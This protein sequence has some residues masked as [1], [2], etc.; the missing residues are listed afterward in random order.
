M[1]PSPV[2]DQLVL[3]RTIARVAS[4]CTDYYDMVRS[5]GRQQDAITAWARDVISEAVATEGELDNFL[6]IAVNVAASAMRANSLAHLP[7]R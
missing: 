2:E 5:A 6:D 4:K 7:E 3:R 1:S